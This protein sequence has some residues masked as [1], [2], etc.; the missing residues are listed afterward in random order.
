MNRRALALLASLLLAAP[1][2]GEEM[3]QPDHSAAATLPPDGWQLEVGLADFL[4][5][6]GTLA[7][8]TPELTVGFR[9]GAVEPFLGFS[10]SYDTSSASVT[11]LSGSS[12]ETIVNLSPGVRFYFRPVEAGRVSPFAQAL[13]SVGIDSMGQ[14]NAPATTAFAL[15]GELAV[16]AEY[17]FSV[18]FGIALGA[19]FDYDHAFGSG[20]GA[21]SVQPQDFASLGGFVTLVMH[22]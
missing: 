22:L 21:S 12:N 5:I 4:A 10:A 14:T 11:G 18:H 17:L 9:F 6:G 3:G 7:L 13:L 16:G 19:A 2:A 8:P 1:A 20:S 15:G